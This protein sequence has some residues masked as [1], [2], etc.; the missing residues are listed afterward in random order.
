MTYE[1]REFEDD[2]RVPDP[3]CGRCGHSSDDH[4]EHE[5]EE[6]G[7]SERATYCV[8]CE[9]W[10]DFVPAVESSPVDL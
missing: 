8:T 10:H 7:R 6:P 5:A 1:A 4:I 3:G 2:A 9:E